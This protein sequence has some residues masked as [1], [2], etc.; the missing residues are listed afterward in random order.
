MPPAVFDPGDDIGP[1]PSL[2][3]E[4]TGLAGCVNQALDVVAAGG[5]VLQSGECAEATINPS[6]QLIRK[7]VTYTGC[8][9]FTHDDYPVM[10][11]L[12]DDGLP[13][14]KLR[15]H[16]LPAADAQAAFDAFTSAESGKV[17]LHWT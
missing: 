6:A 5:S 7:E 9:Y 8:W 12:W 16:D 1:A 3:I 15:T 2:V 13:V 14:A 11:Q 10:R 17:V 4:A